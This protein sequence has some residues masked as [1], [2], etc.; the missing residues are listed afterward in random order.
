[1]KPDFT[2]YT[3]WGGRRVYLETREHDAL[4]ILNRIIRREAI[5]IAGATSVKAIAKRLERVKPRAAESEAVVTAVV[6][7]ARWA[8]E[9]SADDLI[10]KSKYIKAD[11]S[12]PLAERKAALEAG[13]QATLARL[14]TEV[15]PIITDDMLQFVEGRRELLARIERQAVLEGRTTAD[16]AKLVNKVWPQSRRRG[17]ELFT[18][19]RFSQE[20]NIRRAQEFM[21]AEV[22][23][24][25]LWI[26]PMDGRT[27]SRCSP[28]VGTVQ[29]L[30]DI[31]QAPPLH[32]ACRCTFEPVFEGEEVEGRTLKAGEADAAEGFEGFKAFGEAERIQGAA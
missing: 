12:I 13:R 29:E 26:N 30:R 27:C 5:T 1:L 28:L 17:A 10:T 9:Q 8:I 15:G 32:W 31:V 22:I 3:D 20:F 24:R 18:R 11:L 6:D 25:V 14:R 16:T 19:T 23:D 21:D 4:T 7:A 2:D